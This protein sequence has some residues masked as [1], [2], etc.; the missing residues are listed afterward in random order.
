VIGHFSY[1]AEFGGI[2]WNLA[3]LGGIRQVARSSTITKLSAP[4][5]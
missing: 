5:V 1:L 2:W 4:S 3:E